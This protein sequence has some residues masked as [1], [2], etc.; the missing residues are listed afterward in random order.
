VEESKMNGYG[1]YSINDK[2]F[3]LKI[4]D[5]SQ[6]IITSKKSY[7]PHLTYLFNFFVGKKD[8]VIDLGA[9]IGYHTVTLSKLA[10]KGNVIAAEPL[11]EVYYN[12]CAN[13]LLNNC[14]NV[15]ALNKVCTNEN[16]QFVM[17]KIDWSNSGNCR[18]EKKANTLEDLKM[19]VD[20]FMLDDVD[21]P[22]SLIKMDVQGSECNV[23]LGGDKHISAF[24]PVFIVEIEEH[25][26]NAFGKTSK[27]LLNMF[28][29]RDY[30]LYRIM[31][32]YPC[33][34]IAVP[35]E[36]GTFDFKSIVGYDIEVIDR[37]V[38]ETTMRW[39]LYEKA[40]Y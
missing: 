17:E 39:P 26:L 25:H 20:S 7:E 37:P 10:S 24:R 30:V 12:L 22:T 23:I 2:S 35:K 29:E 33:D 27:D 32:E 14:H 18:V 21:I 5:N 1:V 6:K 40:F 3:V 4:G 11:K 19:S 9:N 13:L 36:K 28:I 8:N 34:H 15:D 31:N 16:S 38:K